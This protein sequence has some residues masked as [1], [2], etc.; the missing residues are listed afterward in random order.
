MRLRNHPL[1]SYENKPTWPPRWLWIEG[2]NKNP[3]GEIGILK[4]VTCSS[5]VQPNRCFLQ[6]QHQGSTYVGS[7][8]I[9]DFSFFGRVRKLFQE[10]CGKLISDIG[11]L[12]L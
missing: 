8:A 12:E 3:T 10:H 5:L 11:N 6:I 1:L 2:E 7:I 4:R 9:S